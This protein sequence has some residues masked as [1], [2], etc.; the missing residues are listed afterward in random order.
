MIFK[1]LSTDFVWVISGFTKYLKLSFDPDDS[2]LNEAIS[3]S[4]YLIFFLI[5][6]SSCPVQPPTLTPTQTCVAP[7]KTNP[8]CLL[9]NP[10]LVPPPVSPLSQDW[11][12]DIQDDQSENRTRL[13][14]DRDLHS[15]WCPKWPLLGH[16]LIH[17]HKQIGEKN[18]LTLKLF[19]FGH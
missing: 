7:R 15:I 17:T 4:S 2:S 13:G 5:P 19:F 11:Q 16:P 8:T 14:H 3:T 18:Q 10:S 1:L 12:T 6:L 9:S